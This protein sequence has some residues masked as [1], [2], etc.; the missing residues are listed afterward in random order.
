MRRF[1]FFITILALLVGCGTFST[2]GKIEEKSIQTLEGEVVIKQLCIAPRT[3]KT[4][5]SELWLHKSDG[6]YVL[7]GVFYSPRYFE[8]ASFKISI[9]DKTFN[10]I[11]TTSFDAEVWGY[12]KGSGGIGGTIYT[13]AVSSALS[14]EIVDLLK[15]ASQFKADLNTPLQERIEI[16]EGDNLKVIKEFFI[17]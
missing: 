5:M 9:G 3:V 10:M 6:L 13:R 8:K 16:I 17:N 7:V 4:N 15:N 11:G 1:L 14:D 12:T 2:F